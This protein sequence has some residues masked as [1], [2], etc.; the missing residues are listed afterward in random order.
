MIG[1]CFL[2]ASSSKQVPPSM[3]FESTTFSN[4]FLRSN[5]LEERS[6]NSSLRMNFFVRRGHFFQEKYLKQFI[7]KRLF[8]ATLSQPSFRRHFFK[9]TSWKQVPLYSTKQLP[10][11]CFEELFLG[12]NF[13][14]PQ[15]LALKQHSTYLK[16][17]LGRILVERTF[18]PKEEMC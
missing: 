3:F 1:R 5:L 15:E 6:C 2:A 9:K 18:F 13:F 10:I 14:L 8:E 12:E 7:G 16:Q 17:L 4:F 11:D